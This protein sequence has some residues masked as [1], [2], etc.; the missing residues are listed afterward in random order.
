[1]ILNRAVRR[2]S[3]APSAAEKSPKNS[4]AAEE[5]KNIG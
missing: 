1:M 3:A 5:I 2:R 4:A